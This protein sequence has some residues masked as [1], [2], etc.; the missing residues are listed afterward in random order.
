MQYVLDRVAA[1]LGEDPGISWS[2]SGFLV[3]SGHRGQEISEKSGAAARATS[4][5]APGRRV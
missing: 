4:G 1:A 2:R 3:W 5:K